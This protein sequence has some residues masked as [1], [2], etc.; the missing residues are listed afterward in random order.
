MERRWTATE[1]WKQCDEAGEE[2]IRLQFERGY[3]MNPTFKTHA[4]S[5][6]ERQERLRN[7]SSQAEQIEIARSAA[8]ATRD[9]A[10]AALEANRE[11]KK[12]NVIA[13]LA[14]TAALIAI[15]ISVIGLFLRR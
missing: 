6:L 14:L 15:A 7:E 13:T 11:A 5:W 12:A 2:R 8:S 9:A 4:K 10:D 1:V 3:A